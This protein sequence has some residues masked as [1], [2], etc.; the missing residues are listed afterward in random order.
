MSDRVTAPTQP[1]PTPTEAS[2]ANDKLISH[3]SAV[4]FRNPSH[5]DHYVECNA[6]AGAGYGVSTR[7]D[8]DNEWNGQ[9][10]AKFKIHK[11]TGTT[12]H[13]SNGDEIYLTNP[14][15]DDH[16]VECNAKAGA[17]YGE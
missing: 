17:G 7:K 5:D 14:S 4:Y 6:K 3:G 9:C 16:Y 13:I 8:K 2:T 15:H 10:T 12:G 1:A 11:W